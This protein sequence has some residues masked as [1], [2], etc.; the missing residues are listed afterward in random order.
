MVTTGYFLLPHGSPCCKKDHIRLFLL[1]GLEI[2]FLSLYK[3]HLQFFKVHSVVLDDCLDVFRVIAFDDAGHVHQAPDETLLRVEDD[4]MASQRGYSRRFQAG[5]SGANDQNLLF[6][7][8]F[9]VLIVFFLASD[10]SVDP[11]SDRQHPAGQTTQ[12]SGAGSDLLE[13]AFLHLYG[14]VRVREQPPADS[15][16]IHLVLLE[17]FFS[18]GKV[19]IPFSG[20]HDGLGG[21]LFE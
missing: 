2:R 6:F 1:D 12:T 20:D 21:D 19:G 14:Q 11:A 16:H 9:R 13:A 8:C 5:G 18:K 7:L 10:E 17:H 3:L 15:N 4:F